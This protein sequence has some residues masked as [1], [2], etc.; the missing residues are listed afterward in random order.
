MDL[1]KVLV[2]YDSVDFFRYKIQDKGFKCFPS[3]RKVNKIEKLFRKVSL[4]TNL[5]KNKWYGDW[6]NNLENVDTIIVFATSRY[7]YIRNLAINNQEKRII[8]WYWNPVFRCFNPNDLSFNNIEFWS[9]DKKDCDN[10]GFNYNTTFY[11]DNIKIGDYDRQYD[12]IF[13]GADKGRKNSLNDIENKFKNQGL[14]SY[15]HIVPD[16][17]SPN[18]NNITPLDYKDYLILLNKSKVILDY[19]QQGQSGLTLRPMESI[20][21]K[22]KLIT[23]DTNIV[24]EDFYLKENIFVL[25]RDDFENL[26]TFINS[27]YV[28]LDPSIVN[29]YDFTNWLKR[30]DF[31]E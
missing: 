26:K 30:F 10:Y 17:N 19:L 18:P 9:F 16:K 27:P 5:F 25:G 13:L 29:K 14:K 31:N 8:I 7:D 15:F 12:V 2:I 24:N 22:K 20:F 28:E 21:F 6:K 4:I 3:F 1:N 23:N 11:F